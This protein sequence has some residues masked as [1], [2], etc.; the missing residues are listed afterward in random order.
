MIGRGVT[1]ISL[2]LALSLMVGWRLSIHWILGHPELGE[3]ILIVGSGPFAVEIAKETLQRK[4]VGFR[5]VGFVDNDP[6]LVG[7]SLINPKVIGLT[8]ELASL[9]KRENIDRL[10][11]AIGDR[12]GQFPT[13]ELLKLS[14]SGDVTIEESAAFYER[15]TGRV[16]LDMI[17]PSWLIFSSRGRRARINEISRAVM[18]RA[19][20]L[21]GAI[22]SLPIAIVTAML[23]KL[24][25]RGPILY[26]Q[27]RVGKNGRTFKLMKFRSMRIDAEKDGPV[28]A[29]TDDERTTRVGRVIRKIR[30]DEIP[31]FWNI[32]RGDMNFV[33]PRP[34]RPHFVEQLAQE[35]PY[36]EQRHLMAPGL[37]G[38]AQINYPYGASIED[39]KQKLQYDL[40]YMKN[41]SLAL[42]ATIMFETIKT[43]LFGKG[44]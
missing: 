43:I 41:Q 16:L 7:K 23:I 6:N 30:V 32:L 39:A 13:Q 9:V 3:R 17:R 44:T 36:Y 28:W 20:A 35:I 22:L 37:T 5:V 15:L 8:S 42:D 38:W 40:Y 14:L 18:H 33:G 25:S 4:D 2:P 29:K 27:E 11:V 34:E 24:D 19:I 12:R 10:V 26:K 1:L 21:V 31:Q